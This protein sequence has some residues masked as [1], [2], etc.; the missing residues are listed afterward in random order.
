MWTGWLQRGCF[1]QPAETRKN[2]LR[3]VGR[4]LQV[5]SDL[6]RSTEF[7]SDARAAEPERVIL[8]DLPCSRTPAPVGLHRGGRGNP[9]GLELAH[10]RAQPENLLRGFR[11]FLTFLR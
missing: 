2:P 10:E 9:V 8:N 1:Q 11:N 7:Q 3:G 6:L 5:R 4:D